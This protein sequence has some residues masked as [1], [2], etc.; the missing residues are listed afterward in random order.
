MRALVGV[1]AFVACVATAHATPAPLIPRAALF[2]AP[3]RD[4]PTL[5]PDGARLAYLVRSPQGITNVWLRPVA[6]RRA[7]DTARMVTR[8]TERG[9]GWYRWAGDGRHLL[10][11]RD[12]GGDEN[13]HLVSVDVE[14]GIVRD[15]T[16]FMGVRAEDVFTDPHRP[17]EVLVGLNLRDARVFDLYRVTLSTGAVVLDTQNPGDVITWVPDADFVVRAAV[18]LRPENANTVIRV[19]ESGDAPWQDLVEW[20]FEEAGSDRYQR[21]LSFTRDGSGLYMQWPVGSN[22]TRLV[23][24][25]IATGRITREIASDP[26]CDLWNPFNFAGSVSALAVVQNPRT[27]EPEAVAFEYLLPEWRALTSAARA[28][29]AFLQELHDGVFFLAD[30]DTADRVWLVGYFSDTRSPAYYLYDRAARRAELLFATDPEMSGLPLAPMRSITIP[31]RDGLEIP[32]Y[33]TL[34][35][36]VPAKK[37]PL[38]VNPH[39]GPW[40]RDSWGYNPEVQWLANRGYAVLQVNYRGST[41]FGTRFVNAGDHQMGV[42]AMQHD[43]TDAVRWATRTGI[44]DSTRIGIYGGSYG[45]YATLA[46]LAFT[47]EMYACGVDLVGPSDLRTLIASFPSYWGPRKTRWL[48]RIG[49]VLADEE[50]NRRL[51]PLYHA[52][53]MRAPLL[54]G[55]GANDPRVV[56]A[57]SEA[58]V[59]ALRDRG[60]PVAF[61]V[62]PDEGHGFAREENAQDFYGRMEEF[63]ARHLGG[64]AEPFAPVAGSSADV[65]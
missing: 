27:L 24:A 37:L 35:V 11:I 38:V 40:T 10:Y 8:E 1:C 65:R 52:D 45:G 2:R 31:A 23:E 34:P 17:D 48:R 30:R 64:R 33:L 9:V 22:T 36:G 59:R 25:N 46:G 42:G 32:C 28:D 51:S 41:G 39:G 57:N 62:Y 58:I 63:L 16:P 26:R 12:V 7:D 55:H 29:V 60:V 3:E 15:L 44:A 54:I 50:L 13:N 53:A 20:S 14:R 4:L 21:I 49:D 47:P 56:L 18:A 6:A 5:S 19:R 61:I 43:L